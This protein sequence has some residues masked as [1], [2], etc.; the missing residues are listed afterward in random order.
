MR[1]SAGTNPRGGAQ[2]VFESVSAEALYITS[3]A[4]AGMARISR[5]D[6]SCSTRTSYRANLAALGL[7]DTG[8]G[9]G[10]R[11]SVI[12]ALAEVLPER[13]LRAHTRHRDGRSLDAYASGARP[14]YAALVAKVSPEFPPSRFGDSQQAGIKKK[15]GGGG[16]N[17]TRVRSPQDD[18][19]DT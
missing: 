7:R 18:T 6:A 8:M 11:H 19:E 5:T 10:L 3:A 15:N 17:R 2:G 14:D 1:G 13:P 12:S 16:G 9:E 4:L